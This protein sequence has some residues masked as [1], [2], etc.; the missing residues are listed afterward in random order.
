L[1]AFNCLLQDAIAVHSVNEIDADQSQLLEALSLSVQSETNHSQKN[2]KNRSMLPPTMPQ[3]PYV[4][5]KCCDHI[6]KYGKT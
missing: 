6:K 4:V 2:V 1:D 3:V 5:Q